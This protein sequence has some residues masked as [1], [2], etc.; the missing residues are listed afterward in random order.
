M[1]F[2]GD[3]FSKV[4]NQTKPLALESNPRVTKF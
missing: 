2:V 3:P 1:K 4:D